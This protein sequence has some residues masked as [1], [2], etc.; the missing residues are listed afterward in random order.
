MRLVPHR[1]ATAELQ[2]IR[3]ATGG[4]RPPWDVYAQPEGCCRGRSPLM[5]MPPGAARRMVGSG[6]VI[7]PGRPGNRAFV[8][9]S[10]P[11]A[12][13]TSWRDMG[14]SR[15]PPSSGR[16]S[17]SEAAYQPRP[18]VS[19]V[20]DVARAPGRPL[21]NATRAVMETRFGHDFSSIRV[22]SDDRAVTYA[23][24]RGTEHS[25]GAPVSM[26]PV[27]QPRVISG[28]THWSERSMQNLW[29]SAQPRPTVSWVT[30]VARAPGR[31]LDN[32]T[33][34][35]M[36]TRFGHDFS[37]IRVHS[38]DRAAASAERLGATAYAAGR[39]LVFARGQYAPGTERGRHLLA[40]ELAHVVQQSGQR[41]GG[42]QV[43]APPTM[44][45]DAAAERDA[46]SWAEGSGGP[47][48][49]LMVPRPAVMPSIAEKILKF[50]AKQLEK[51]T[52][53]TVSKHIARHARRIAGRAIH[54][55]FKNPKEIRYLL[56]G[57]VRE[58][59][60]IAGR[61][62]T[63]GTQRVIEEAGIRITRQGTG[64]PGKFRLVIQKVF[65]REIGT[66]GE[67]VLRVVLDQTGRIV[68]AFPADRLVAIG[69]TAAGIEALTEG[70]ARAGEAVHAQAERAEAAEKARE[71]RI[72]IWEF[73]PFI[74]DI[75][76]GSL[77]EGED[78]MLRQEREI[79][80]LIKETLD[81]VEKSEQRTLGAPE[82]HELEQLIRVA[83]ASPFVLADT[84][85][86]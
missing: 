58:A 48:E 64:T 13:R 52:V 35:V 16:L 36:E 70:T 42:D 30:D 39:H 84:D 80:A 56:Q 15:L 29:R 66:Q 22:H 28:L 21:D 77:N 10:H 2:P 65:D 27:H 34:A 53:R 75:W 83:I 40:H 79:A 26:L 59:T 54:S 73:V 33:R 62:P 7:V 74:G 19:R 82:R 47:A 31:P 41:P 3:D 44:V 71:E 24:T 11:R 69:L 45:Y 6:M 18:T 23:P 60:E 86:D 1:C 4:T 50:A 68:T 49:P 81:D 37:S 46:E 85:S 32:A 61:H 8:M 67:R 43:Q 9:E 5:P 14:V 57:V 76:G 51:R 25:S 20:T 78:E 38:D 72:D 17:I 63:A 12:R 55:I